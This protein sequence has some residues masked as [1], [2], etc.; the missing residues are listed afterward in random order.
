V[1]LLQTR[2]YNLS[3]GLQSTLAGGNFKSGFLSGGISSTLGSL[4]AGWGDAGQLFTGIAG[5]GIGSVIGGGS[6]IDGA[7]M[8]A[9][10]VGLNHLAERTQGIKPVN[11]SGSPDDVYD[12]LIEKF[13]ELKDGAF[14]KEAP[15]DGRGKKY[16]HITELV[17]NPPD[18]HAGGPSN[19]LS[20]SDLYT[21]KGIKF[22]WS[23]TPADYNSIQQYRNGYLFQIEKNVFRTYAQFHFIGRTNHPVLT[24]KIYGKNNF[25]P[26]LNQIYRK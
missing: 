2:M 16:W 19:R 4:T 11:L 18:S 26:I 22:R 3:G 1:S 15:N 25:Q 21:K 17:T 10:T 20:S 8:G 6:F 12:G 5:G 24:L 13:I 14:L 7:Q 23:I 9:I